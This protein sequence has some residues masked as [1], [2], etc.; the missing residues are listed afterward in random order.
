MVVAY[1]VL[2]RI[3]VTVT[4]A[5]L[6]GLLLLPLCGAAPFAIVP[7]TRVRALRFMLGSLIGMLV[8]FGLVLGAGSLVAWMLSDPAGPR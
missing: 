7:A 8:V 1:A 3:G 4:D 5:W 2:L 6:V